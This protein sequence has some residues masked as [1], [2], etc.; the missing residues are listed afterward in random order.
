MSNALTFLGTGTSQGIPVIGCNCEV[1]RSRD[2]RDKRLRTSAFVEYCGLKILIDAGPD[3]RRQMLGLPPDTGIPDAIL[4]THNHVDHIGGLDD[5][6]A[7]NY[8]RQDG[9]KVAH[10]VPLYCEKHTME[11]VEK[12]FYYAFGESDYPGIPLFDVHLIDSKPFSINGVEIVPIRAFHASMPVLGFRFGPLAYITDA[13]LIPEEGFAALE[14]VSTLII[15]TVRRTEHIS[16]FSLPQALD[17]IRRTGARNGWLTHLSHQ[18]P[19]H[20]RLCAELPAGVAPA[21]DGLRITF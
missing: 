21:W 3:F 16:H 11:G 5:V 4:L 7:F 15:N 12:M 14:G 13:N 2:V 17:V 9:Y 6:R 18:L 1:C 10:P 20:A 8:R 19:P